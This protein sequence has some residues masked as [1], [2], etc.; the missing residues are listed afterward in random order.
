MSVWILGFCISK[1]RKKKQDGKDEGL[2]TNS[3]QYLS[4]FFP[5]T[6]TRLG[7]ITGLSGI[8]C[9][10]RATPARKQQPRTTEKISSLAGDGSDSL[11]NILNRR[12]GCCYL[13]E[14]ITGTASLDVLGIT[15]PEG[16]PLPRICCGLPR[17]RK[18]T[19]TGSGGL[20]QLPILWTCCRSKQ[21]ER[22]LAR[23]RFCSI[24]P[25]H[26]PTPTSMV[27][28][29]FGNHQGGAMTDYNE[30]EERG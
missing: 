27:M 15:T 17:T 19:T 5:R 18:K 28:L 3:N 10:L 6:E 22:H 4:I 12:Y 14:G 11:P 7:D 9:S 1:H 16:P 30:S 24:S 20:R 26:R 2:T 13:I 23:V 8:I 25:G 29:L 21:L